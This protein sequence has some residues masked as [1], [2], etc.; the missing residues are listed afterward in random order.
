[1]QAQHGAIQAN[2]EGEALADGRKGDVIRVKN[3]ASGKVIDAQV[4][5]IG[6]VSSTF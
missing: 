6:V 1:M 5:G 4:T 2:T 3:V